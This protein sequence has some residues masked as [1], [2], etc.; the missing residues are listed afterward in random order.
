MVVNLADMDVKTVEASTYRLIPS[1]YPP[2]DVLERVA[3]SEDFVILFEIESLTN[4]RLR[5]EVGDIALVAKEDRLYGGGTSLIMAPFTHPPVSGQGGRFNND[6]GVFYCAAEFDTALEE[7][8]Y[9]RARFFLDSNT[10]PTKFDMRELITDLNQELHTI[11]GQQETLA[12]TYDPDDY[13]AGQELGRKLKA[14]NSWGLEYSSVRATGI[15]YAVFRP[16]ALSNCRQSR[17]FEYHFDGKIISH[18]M[19]KNEIQ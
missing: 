2:I 7:T 13:S 8:K 1:C 3:S 14:A 9:H 19:L 18:V 12:D 10:G 5:E 15:C 16:P 11:A 4:D 17:H 6:F